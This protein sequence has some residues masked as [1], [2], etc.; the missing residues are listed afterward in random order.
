MSFSENWERYYCLPQLPLLPLSA[1]RI[2]FGSLAQLG[3]CH[4]PPPCKLRYFS[5]QCWAPPR[6]DFLLPAS[7]YPPRAC[8]LSCWRVT[9][10]LSPLLDCQSLLEPWCPEPHGTQCALDTC[11]LSERMNEWNGMFSLRVQHMGLHYRERACVGGLCW[12]HRGLR[13]TRYY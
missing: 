13:D 6:G 1:A 10:C 3:T 12:H 11:V 5:P 2:R 8:C 7:P 4:H 9:V